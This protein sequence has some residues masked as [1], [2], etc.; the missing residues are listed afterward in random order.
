MI[1]TAAANLLAGAFAWTFAEYGLHHW[2]GH[3]MLGKTTFSKLHLRHHAD[4]RYFAPTSAKIAA[5]IPANALV[6]AA[7]IWGFGPVV[8]IA[9]TTGFATMYAAYEVIHRRTHTHPPR[10]WYSRWTRRHHLYHHF[11]SPKMNHGVTT[12]LW[13]LV[14]RTHVAPPDVIRVPRR[15]APAWLCDPASGDVRP[16][17]ARDYAIVGRPTRE[18]ETSSFDTDLAAAYAG[19]APTA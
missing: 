5:A 16:E 7:T 10:G 4:Q 19:N 3:R 6:A 9:F 14:F 12:P 15:Q 11:G 13:D 8:G 17:Y 18:A 2:N 1:L